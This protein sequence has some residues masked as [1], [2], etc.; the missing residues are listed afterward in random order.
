MGE[1]L[2]PRQGWFRT[3]LTQS[4]RDELRALAKTE[5]YT[6]T[7]YIDKTLRE[8]LSTRKEE[9]YERRVTPCN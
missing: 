5:G 4:E 8:A 1:S 2:R 6:V 7:G 9:G 3:A